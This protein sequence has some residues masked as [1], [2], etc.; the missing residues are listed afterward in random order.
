MLIDGL[1]RDDESSFVQIHRIC[2][3][4]LLLFTKK[5]VESFEIICDSKIGKMYLTEW[6]RISIRLSLLIKSIQL[7]ELLVGV[8]MEGNKGGIIFGGIKGKIM[9]GCYRMD[10][11]LLS[12]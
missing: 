5:Y 12:R 4:R 10:A 1:H 7:D 2:Y 3:K 8:M 6:R 11:R 9:K